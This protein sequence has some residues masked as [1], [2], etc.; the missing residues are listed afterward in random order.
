MRHHQA[1][2]EQKVKLLELLNEICKQCDVRLDPTV[3]MQVQVE[4]GGLLSVWLS[5]SQSKQIAGGDAP[6]VESRAKVFDGG[7]IK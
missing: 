4:G 7:A 6:L 1:T 3:A 2:D 5:G